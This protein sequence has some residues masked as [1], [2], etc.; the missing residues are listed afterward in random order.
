[1]ESLFGGAS[2]PAKVHAA[3]QISGNTQ[4]AFEGDN[5]T[6]ISN[7]SQAN[8]DSG[9]PTT[10]D[11]TNADE[12]TTGDACDNDNDN[13]G[14]NDL[15][16]PLNNWVTGFVAASCRITGGGSYVAAATD[17]TKKD[18]DGDRVIDGSECQEG[19]NPN[20]ALSQPPNGSCTTST[21]TSYQG[22]NTP[23]IESCG[24]DIDGIGI[25]TERIERTTGINQAEG[26]SLS[27]GSGQLCNID[28]GRAAAP[29]NLAGDASN[30][31][32]DGDSDAD[33][34]G[35]AKEYHIWG[36]SP[37]NMDSDGDGC[38]DGIEVISTDG[39]CDVAFGDFVNILSKWNTTS[40]SANWNDSGGSPGGKYMDYDGSNS[41]GFGDFVIVLQMWNKSQA[42]TC[43]AANGCLEP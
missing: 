28:G 39:V 12:D 26:S 25:K 20:D 5:C 43:T 29:G 15:A 31:D 34:L 32:L 30:G 18:S 23:Y 19:K 22:S 41:L 10:G 4:R 33:G 9:R 16:E 17:P 37:A 35:D 6:N 13:D 24:S 27:C 21:G 3:F 38:N 14:M 8:V 42:A 36:T 7:A 11:R 1:M 2:G 40:L